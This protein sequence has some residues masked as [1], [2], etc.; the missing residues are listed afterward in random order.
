MF[1]LLGEELE[2]GLGCLLLHY[3]TSFFEI[4]HMLLVMHIPQKLKERKKAFG[5]EQLLL[6]C[7]LLWHCSNQK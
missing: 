7:L 3:A 2:L 5:T 6:E 1:R 4:Y